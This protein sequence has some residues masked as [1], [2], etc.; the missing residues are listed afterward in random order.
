MEGNGVNLEGVGQLVDAI[1]DD[2][3]MGE[4]TFSAR[5]QWAGGTKA[6]VTIDKL[7]AGGNNIAPPDRCHRL[8]MDEPPQVG[9]EDKYPNPVEYLAAAVCGCLTAGMATNG[10]LFDT[11]F[12]KI[13]MSVDVHFDL[14]GVFGLND[15]A[16]N[17]A[18]EM[19]VN[20]NAK[21]GEGVSE[22]DIRKVWDVISRKSPLKQTL[23]LPLKI[24]SNLNI[25]A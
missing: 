12:E 20:I 8:Y 1:K 16:P 15:A 11:V 24:T 23:E 17:G 21:G 3:S 25:E 7:T 19:T 5:S 22:E 2:P 4:V 10:A 18:L 14:G 9:G 6:E 13:D